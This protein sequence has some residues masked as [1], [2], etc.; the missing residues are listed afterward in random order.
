MSISVR[1]SSCGKSMRVPDEAAGRSI[2]CRFCHQPFT[3]R[4][5]G[6]AGGSRVSLPIIVAGAVFVI[7][8]IAVI[9]RLVGVW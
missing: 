7:G 6:S 2:R 3:A 1:C 9:L 4:A 5:D 8:L